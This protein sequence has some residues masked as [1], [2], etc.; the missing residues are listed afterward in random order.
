ME[1]RRLPRLRQ[2]LDFWAIPM[3]LSV[4]R[5]ILEDIQRGRCFYCAKPM[6]PTNGHVDHFIPWC[7]YPVDLGHNFVVAHQ[8]CNSAKADHLA[9]AN[10]LAAWAERNQQYRGQLADAFN[11][12]GVLHDLPTSARIASWAYQTTFEAGGL[13]WVKKEN[14]ICLPPDWQRPLRSLLEY[15]MGCD[16]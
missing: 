1:A 4:V 9:A 14:M 12:R 6:Q 5:T 15:S 16:S 11:E 13:T 2:K 7:K 8:A 3:D 10:Y